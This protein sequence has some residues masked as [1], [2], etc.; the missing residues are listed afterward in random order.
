[1]ALAQMS[2]EYR[3]KL[4]ESLN[5]GFKF[6]DGQNLLKHTNSSDEADQVK[7]EVAPFP[8]LHIEHYNRMS[9]QASYL[10]SYPGSY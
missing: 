8:C 3:R 7:D 10:N 9:T 6:L 1:M 2:K 5:A 4:P